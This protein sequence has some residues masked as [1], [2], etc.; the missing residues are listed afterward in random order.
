M[1]KIA[2]NESAQKIVEAT[3]NYISENPKL[4]IL[5]GTTLAT[6]C[7][8]KLVQWWRNRVHHNTFLEM[9]L[10]KVIFV[11][12][13]LEPLELMFDFQKTR[14]FINDVFNSIY[15][16]AQDPKISGIYIRLGSITSTL[17]LAL[18][19]E[20]RTAISC[21]TEKGKIAV[22]YAEIYDLKMY[23]LASAFT[24]IYT[25][26]LGTLAVS[27]TIATGVFLKNTMKKLNIEID[28]FQR[29][30]YKTALNTFTEEKFTPEHFES[31][32]SLLES[33]TNTIISDIATSR[34]L[35]I[36]KV[37]DW[38]DQGLFTAKRACE[39]HLVDG[40]TDPHD[41]LD[42]IE[43]FTKSKPTFLYSGL[44]SS[45]VGPLYPDGAKN[46]LAVIYLSGQIHDGESVDGTCGGDTL[47]LAIRSATKDTKVKGII[48][49]VDSPGGSG[50]ASELINKA[51]LEAKKAGKIV[52]I[53]MGAVAASG[54]YWVS[55]NADCIVCNASTITGSIGVVGLK[56]NL[57][58]FFSEWLG[59]TYDFIETSKSSTMFSTLHSLEKGGQNEQKWNEMIDEM[60]ESFTQDV[61]KARN[62]EI[63]KIQEYAQGKVYAGAVAKELGLVDEI[64]GFA[65]AIEVTKRLCKID[66]K[67]NISF[68]RYPKPVTLLTVLYAKKAQNSRDLEKSGV[69]GGFSILNVLL[70]PFYT[71]NRLQQII[72]PVMKQY[73]K[74]ESMENDSVQAICMDE[75]Y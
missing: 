13:P 68:V 50:S 6:Y 3:K 22:C 38:I 60:Y 74:I 55:M 59:V 36:E 43:E 67:E 34:K 53:S 44:Y 41:I 71:L 4:A 23:Y 9:D 42:K 72:D 17:P 26:Q 49:R 35:K 66:E 14:I 11:F 7:V 32:N 73:Q 37:K 12:K 47:A 19:E 64:G 57:R 69:F 51:I 39:Q 46:T 31:S 63:G 27:G 61:S 56:P 8:S 21:F 25:H 18:L 5:A 2:L 48:I 29:K 16:A 10:S 75:T 58:K 28:G 1:S 70:K 33:V 20:F 45:R 24:K 15:K 62:I 65:Q 54:G 30:K 40:L 52:V